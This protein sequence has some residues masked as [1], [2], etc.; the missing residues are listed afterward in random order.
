MTLN[1]KGNFGSKNLA[2]QKTYVLVS[3]NKVLWLIR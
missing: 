2:T 1:L 3:S